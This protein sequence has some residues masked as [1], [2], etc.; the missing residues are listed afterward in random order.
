MASQS[1]KLNEPGARLAEVIDACASP[2]TAFKEKEVVIP[3]QPRHTASRR[4]IGP[5]GTAARVVLGTLFFMDGAIGARLVLIHGHLQLNLDAAALAIGLL[6]F[7][8]A[9]LAGQWIRSRGDASRLAATGPV[10]T[11]LN[12]LV[13]ILLVSTIYISPISF[14]GSAT[15]VFYGASML[16]AAVRGYA[17]CEVLAVSNWLLRRDDQ[18]GCLVLRLYKP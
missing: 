7:P 16:L 5:I 13:L 8:A 4:Q 6:G 18:I 9:L 15:L 1:A 2:A 17:G 10:A 14:I 3:S 12:I 11:T